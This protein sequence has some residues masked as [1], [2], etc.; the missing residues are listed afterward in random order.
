MTKEQINLVRA[1]FA[2]IEP[3]A[4]EAAV[5]F[6]ARLFDLDPELRPLFKGDIRLQGLKLMRTIGMAVAA[7]DR[8]E[9]IVP[10][11]RALGARHAVYGV[12]DRDYETVA[13]ALLWTLEKALKSDFTA[14]TK[15]A[16]T[17]VYNLLAQ[18]MKDGSREAAQN[19]AV[20]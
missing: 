18:A 19:A 3:A 6:Y 13:R 8:L 9:E 2:K 16:W 17:E 10:A 4:E 20:L 1:S 7:L 12:K 5:L 14:E 11:V 15:A